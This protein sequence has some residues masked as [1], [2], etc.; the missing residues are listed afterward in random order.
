[1]KKDHKVTDY[2]QYYKGIVDD[3]L[4]WKLTNRQFDYKQRILHS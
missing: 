2:I 4:C 1:M 3:K